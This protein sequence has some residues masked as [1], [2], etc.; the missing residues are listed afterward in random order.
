MLTEFLLID[1]AVD[2]RGRLG[3]SGRVLGL[4]GAELLLRFPD[5]LLLSLCS[6]DVDKVTVDSPVSKCL[7]P[8]VI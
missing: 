6:E 2:G 5:G 8:G 7:S 1:M 3:E 4:P